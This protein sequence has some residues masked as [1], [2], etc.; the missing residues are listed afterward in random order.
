MS[1]RAR[2]VIITSIT[3]ALM[4]VLSAAGVYFFA[5]QAFRDS[6]DNAL[7]IRAQSVQVFFRD[8]HDGEQSNPTQLPELPHDQIPDAVQ[9]LT[10]DG[11][12]RAQGAQDD[13][14]I[15]PNADEI[16]AAKSD[17]RELYANH[18][19]KGTV[20]RTYTRSA[21]RGV[22]VQVSRPTSE[23][24][25]SLGKLR[26]YLAV[27]ILITICLSEGIPAWEH[28][29]VYAQGRERGAQLM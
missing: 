13:I 26:E 10:R 16:S 25:R 2:L 28:F 6:L 17:G 4:S 24:L 7:S 27:I 20:F 11:K 14:R 19:V 5:Q 8:N 1:Y 18:N 15:P 23:Y 9:I 29:G 22:A 21:G 12:V 3:V